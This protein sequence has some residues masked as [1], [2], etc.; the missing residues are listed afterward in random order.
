MNESNL[1]WWLRDVVLPN[2]SYSRIESANTAPGFPDVHYQ[3]KMDYTGTIELKYQAKNLKV[4]FT[5]SKK[6]L[7]DSQRRWIRNNIKH[8]GTVWII[9]EAVP[10]IFV[11]HGSSADE[12]NGS[13]RE[14]LHK[15]SVAVLNRDSP[16]DSAFKL[17]NILMEVTTSA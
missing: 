1:W 9:A 12:F 8:G 3:I 15:I 16:E 5:D 14:N 10:D 2:G 4:P 17:V 6:G 13:T 7:R 11:I